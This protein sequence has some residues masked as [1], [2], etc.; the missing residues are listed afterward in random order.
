MEI[1]TKVIELEEAMVVHYYIF[2]NLYTLK[3]FVANLEDPYLHSNLVSTSSY[4][5]HL[6]Q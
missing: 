2:D 1:V 3:S 5:K 6:H 4:L